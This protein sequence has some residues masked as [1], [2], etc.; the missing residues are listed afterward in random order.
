M[1]KATQTNK[2]HPT[3]LH[4]CNID[5]EVELDPYVKIYSDYNFWAKKYNSWVL[6]TTCR[7]EEFEIDIYHC[8][9]CGE[10]LPT[11]ILN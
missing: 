1:I 6:K 8:P 11:I 10:K 4:E 7:D 3:Y 9:Y 5:D 2:P